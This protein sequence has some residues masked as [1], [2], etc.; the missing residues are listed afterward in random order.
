M[1]TG[2]F[3]SFHI[4]QVYQIDTILVL[5]KSLVC[6]NIVSLDF[7]FISLIDFHKLHESVY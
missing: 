2:H 7:E 5:F 6:V 4:E 3:L 1:C